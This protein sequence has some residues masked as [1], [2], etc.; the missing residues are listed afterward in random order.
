[1][2]N[3][4]Y[5]ISLLFV[6]SSLFAQ[7]KD[8]EYTVDNLKSNSKYSDFGT[9]Y[10]QDNKIIF[11]SSR[12]KKLFSRIF[13]ANKQPFL[14]LYEGTINLDGNV[15]EVKKF[16]KRL[17]TK[18][19]EAAVSFTPDQKT[20]YF[21]RNNYFE[22]KLGRDEEGVTDI[23]IYRASIAPDGGWTN[24]ISLPFNNQNY[25]VAHPAVSKDGK[26]LY[27]ASDMPGTLGGL[28]IFVVDIHTDGTY[29]KPKNLGKAINTSGKEMFP[30]IDAENIL[31]FS[32]DNGK[33]GLGGLDVYA[34]KIYDNS[35]SD[36]IHL[37]KPINSDKDDFGYI[38]KNGKKINEGYFS[39]NRSG[40]KGDDDIYHF[41]SSPPLK[42]E[43]NQTV[44]GVVTNNTTK[45]PIEN[46]VV[47]VFDKKDNEIESTTTNSK[48]Q[49]TLTVKC[50]DSYKVV[51]SDIKYESNSKTFT[52]NEEA[53]AKNNLVIG[54]EPIEVVEIK[55]RIVVNID[56]IY[57]DFNKAIIR[58]DA[59]VELDK[60]VAVM[61]K[62]PELLIEAGSHTDSRGPAQY[63]EVLSNRRA[64]ATIKYITARGIDQSRISAKGY[65]E[66]QLTNNCDGSVKCSD[67]EH[68]INRRT[69]FV[70]LNPTVL[71]Y[72]TIKKNK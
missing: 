64:K 28:D 67:A 69:E 17:N 44:H 23:A 63:N 70:I 60:V 58:Q 36:I 54:L 45:E 22:K 25:S 24:I 72:K 55:E 50:S 30:F 41:V 52:A 38:L 47:V 51:A 8:G 57:F 46:A 11:S 2:K 26:K 14:N 31:Y 40:G 20:V 19:H 4:I 37:K 71:G 66:S 33:G 32:S 56:P 16:S 12:D 49:F 59:T 68:Q 7:T 6:F 18:Y 13:K 34:A 48:G 65:G 29:G 35:I 5:I 61:I 15:S 42:I 10:Y 43:C 1:M 27:F 9:A 62:Y 21:T 39:S 3:S 53:N